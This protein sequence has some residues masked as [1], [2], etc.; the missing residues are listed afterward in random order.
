MHSV[1]GAQSDAVGFYQ[2][3]A[4][5]ARHRERPLSLRFVIFGGEA[6]DPNRLTDWFARHGEACPTLVNMY[7][8]T[9]T[10]VHVTWKR[11]TIADASS[12]SS[13]IGRPI[14][15]LST[16]VL[17]RGKNLAPIGV[18]GDLHVGG[19]G[20]ARGYLGRPDLTAER[21]V[22]DP[23]GAPGE[24]LYRSGDLVRYRADGTLEFHG[25]IDH[26]VKIRGFRIELGEIEAVLSRQPGVRE[27]VVVARETQS[28]D[29]A[30]VAYLVASDGETLTTQELR[31]ALRR[32]L[33]D[34][35][36]PSA[37]S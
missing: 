24:R 9:E 23:F 31:A 1:H 34:Y 20:L 14:A 29:T 10:T 35:M 30:L 32:M 3:D 21:F 18:Q 5:D 15:D 22:P 12:D 37:L 4:A 33:P 36:I 7:G 28:G 16:F 2:L 19:A 11:M 27:A 6:L 13:P 8:I 17:D 25:R 26:Q